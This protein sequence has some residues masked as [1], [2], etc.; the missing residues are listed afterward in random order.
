MIFWKA[1]TPQE[2]QRIFYQQI[3]LECEQNGEAL[4][5]S[6]PTVGSVRSFGDMD[7][8]QSGIGNYTVPMDFL[9]EYGY[10]CAYLHFGV[11]YEGITYAVMNGRAV[12]NSIPSAFCAI[13]K[14]PS[15]MNQWRRG[16]HFKG[17]EV[18]VDMCYLVSRLLPVLGAKADALDFLE[19]NI[20][21]T[22]LPD[23]M[24]DLILRIEQSLSQGRLT[25]AL[26]TSLVLEFI[27]LLLHPDNRSMFNCQEE[28][29]LKPIPLGNRSIYITREDIRKIMQAHDRIADSA[30]TFP[31]SYVLSRELDISEQKLK[32]G[33]LNLY[34]ETLWDYANKIR[35]N[36]AVDL[37]CKTDM[38]I[39][40]ISQSV[41]YQ[42]RAAF[43]SMFKKWSGVTPLKFRT[44]FASAD[45]IR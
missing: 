36:R 11:I 12:A 45:S 8:I 32:V 43:N 17:I 39:S 44:Q 38:S 9:V 31:N 40:D 42:S 7:R 21:Y 6:N 16:Q 33:F 27:S 25:S 18:S 29:F 35:M 3:G 19:V 15:G 24:R 2:Y 4:Y 5:W 28:D 13:E 10:P 22:R 37:L 23:E 34:Q 20:R 41:G 26:Q 14:S 1:Q 30:D